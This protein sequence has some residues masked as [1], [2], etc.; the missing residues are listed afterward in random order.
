MKLGDVLKKERERK[1]L[2]LEDT[3]SKLG[4]ADDAYREVEAGSSPAEKWG[5]LLARIAIK[6]ETPTS[7]LLADSG[8]SA[9]CK[10]GQAGQLI[11]KHRERRQKTA[12]QMA[13]QLEIPKEE[14]Q[15]IEAG[16]SGIEEYGPLLLHFAEL[17]EQPV[18]NL[19][20][21]CG[22]PLDKLD[23]YP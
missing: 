7:R 9:D 21:P 2:S 6:L 13:E 8:K 18:F 12:E 10:P 19:F 15:Q 20:Y 11:Q 1:K 14:Y 17:I 4:L 3:A 23:D 22:L 16:Q 5:P